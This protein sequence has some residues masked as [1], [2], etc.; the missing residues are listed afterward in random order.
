MMSTKSFNELNDMECIPRCL[1]VKEKGIL[2]KYSEK[3]TLN[4]Q[5]VGKV[6]VQKGEQRKSYNVEGYGY[7][8][9][10]KM[11]YLNFL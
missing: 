3:C 9:K 2:K 11:D 8:L 6:S 7:T 4:L 10:G 1:F 5:N